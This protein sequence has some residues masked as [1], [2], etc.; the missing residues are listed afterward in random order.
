MWCII[1]TFELRTSSF[2]HKIL[3]LWGIW[4]F[5]DSLEHFVPD[6]TCD[7]Y[8]DFFIDYILRNYI[9]KLHIPSV[10]KRYWTNCKL[11]SVQARLS[12]RRIRVV[13]IET[14]SDN[15][16]IVGLL[17]PNA[18][19]KTVLQGFSLTLSPLLLNTRMCRCEVWTWILDLLA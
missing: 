13:R 16:H 17:V 11:K 5:F 19:V 12:H 9:S 1:E 14:T 3:I 6:V 7:C 15:Q 18:A 8:H 2:F 10:K 4:S